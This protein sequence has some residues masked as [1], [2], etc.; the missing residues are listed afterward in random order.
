MNNT[1][2]MILSFVGGAGLGALGS[3][4]FL[5]KRYDDKLQVEIEAARQYYANKKPDVT[6][7]DLDKGDDFD[8]ATYEKYKKA[9]EDYVVSSGTGPQVATRPNH[10]SHITTDYTKF[11]NDQRDEK[12]TSDDSHAEAI[13]RERAAERTRSPKIIREEEFEADPT[14]ESATIQYY[15]EN[16][17]MVL[18]DEVGNNDLVISFNEVKDYLGDTLDKY[19]FTESGNPQREMYVRNFRNK[20]DYHI[21]KISGRYYEE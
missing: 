14:F 7:V 10:G 4:L 15:T 9:Q 19:G 3:A 21:I 6:V 13:T 2:K 18:D 11:L 17:V 1:I 5:K 12:E 8:Q 16:G 20:T